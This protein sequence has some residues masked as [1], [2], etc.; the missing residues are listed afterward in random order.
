MK[1]DEKE[2]KI[3]KQTENSQIEPYKSD[4]HES[5][6]LPTVQTALNKSTE[7]TPEEM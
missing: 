1:Q 5:M 2:E 3:T 4:T 7:T 6:L